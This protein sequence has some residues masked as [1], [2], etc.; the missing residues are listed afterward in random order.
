MF[1][2]THL[3]GALGPTVG[4]TVPTSRSVPS[5]SAALGLVMRLGGSVAS[6][7][8][9]APGIGSWALVTDGEGNE[10]VLWENATPA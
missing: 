9:T 10:L 4:T 8:R 3:D 2:T 6:E 1:S 5:L 7:V